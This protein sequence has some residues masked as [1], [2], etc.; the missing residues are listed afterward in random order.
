MRRTSVS[1]ALMLLL[2]GCT[3][4][5]QRFEQPTEP[6]AGPVEAAPVSEPVQIGWSEVAE[7][8]LARFEGQSAV[9]GGKLYVFGGYTDDSVIPKSYA[10]SVYDP[11]SDT[12]E[13]LADMPRPITHAGTAVHGS[14]VYLVGG[15]VGSVNPG[16]EE[17]LS[18]S[19]EVWT[20]NTIADEWSPLVILPE[21]RGAGALAVVGDTLHYLGGTHLD[22][23]SALM[24]HFT[25]K[26]SGV[27]DWEPAPPMKQG[28]NHLAA[29]VIGEKIYAIGGQTGHN[30]SLVTQSAVEMYDPGAGVWQER[31]SLPHGIG[32]IS[33]STFVVN[34]K[35]VVVGGETSNFG[36]YTDEVWVYDPVANSWTES[37]SFPLEQ[38]SMMG[39]VIGETLYLTG[40]SARTLQTFR[41]A[42][43]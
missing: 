35:I 19:D 33:N 34:G 24:D 4:E 25:L 8:P 39:G 43:Q 1:L 11:A 7:A 29:V 5:L 16:S 30:E 10:A 2:G 18:A 28:R 42:L 17:K 31:A 20:Y 38:N 14:S 13:K 41:G 40:G 36:T 26:L 3:F 21:A 23:E 12:W 6:P 9:V 22:R 37:T 32:H 27:H 15:V